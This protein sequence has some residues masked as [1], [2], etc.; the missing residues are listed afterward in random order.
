MNDYFKNNKD[1]TLQPIG[2][3]ESSFSNLKD[4]PFQGSDECP[5]ARVHIL[6]K[7]SKGLEGLKPGQEII[8][9]TLLDKASRDTLKCRP[10]NDPEQP[11][12][13]VFATRSP[14]RPNPIGLHQAK[15]ISMDKGILNVHPLE[16]LDKT[17]VVDIKPVIH[18]QTDPDEVNPYFSRTELNSFM[19]YSRQASAKGLLNGLNGNLSIRKKEIALITRS[20]SA[21]GY[22]TID[23]LCVMDLNSGKIIWGRGKLSSE[24]VMHQEIYKNQPEAMAVVHTHPISILTLDGLIGDSILESVD[25]FEARALRSQLSKVPAHEPG[26]MELARSVGSRSR[27]YKCVIMRSHG[28]TCWGESLAQAMGLC[29]ELE[30]L[31]RIELNTL[32]LKS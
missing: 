9:M 20:G 22:L 12:R 19:D 23:D 10:R 24:S 30:A 13:G 31:A 26:S 5:P 15:I 2:Y 8:I 7:F 29:D 14:N 17:P 3:V 4:C 25:I 6:P 1:F 16:V 21:K 18:P 32:M 11:P 28:L 27:K